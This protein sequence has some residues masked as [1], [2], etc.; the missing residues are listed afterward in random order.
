V[1]NRTALGGY[2]T[3]VT[4]TFPT[5]ADPEAVRARLVPLLAD[6]DSVLPAP[7]P[8]LRI[9]Q[10]GKEDWMASVVF[11]TTTRGGRSN[12]VWSIADAFPEATVD[13]KVTAL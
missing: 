8:Q 9:D 1:I 10:A 2:A 5:E 3:E 12:V 7:E 13:A 11:W 6:L 4:V